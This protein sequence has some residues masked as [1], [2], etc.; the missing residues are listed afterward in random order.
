MDI[1]FYLNELNL[2]LQ[3]LNKHIFEFIS[4]LDGFKLKL[5]ILKEHISKNQLDLFLS[6]KELA[7]EDSTL[8]FSNFDQNI[9][10]LLESFNNRFH[11]VYEINKF[12]DLFYS[13]QTCDILKQPTEYHMELCDLQTDFDLKQQASKYGVAFWENVNSVKYPKLKF[14]ICKL[15]CIFTSTY[16]CE[17][18]FSAMKTIKSEK[19]S[20]LTD[21]HLTELLRVKYSNLE[22]DWSECIL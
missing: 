14:L 11:D 9:K 19:R 21:A 6:C 4:I 15:L 8:D 22:I 5:S 13:P 16:I 17:E 1:T 20:S 7:T 3:G 12:N 18:A 2:Q 10:Q